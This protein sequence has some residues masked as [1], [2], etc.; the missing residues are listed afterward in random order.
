[1][2]NFENIKILIDEFCSVKDRSALVQISLDNKTWNYGFLDEVL[3]PAASLMKIVLAVTLEI[4]IQKK[5]I[6]EQQNFIA[7]EILDSGAGASVLKSLSSN[8][9]FS[10]AELITLSVSTSDPF[11]T[12][13]LL[14]MVKADHLDETLRL[15]G[16]KNSRFGFDFESRDL[17]NGGWTSAMEALKILGFGSNESSFPITS[18]GLQ[19]SILNSRIPI[20]I[21]DNGTQLSHKTGTLLSVAHDVAKIKFASGFMNIAFLTEN[22]SDTLQTGYEMGIC[23]RRIIENLGLIPLGTRSHD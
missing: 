19:N 20:G 11:V 4:Q 23:T 16:C 22:Q 18:R 1:M 10:L 14:S 8:H 5:T 2:S 3:R 13:F 12:K 21:R 9:S 15:M 17:Q 6:D 7:G